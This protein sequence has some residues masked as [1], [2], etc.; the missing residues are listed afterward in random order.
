MCPAA[1]LVVKEAKTKTRCE[2]TH[3]TRYTAFSL[4]LLIAAEQLKLE[5]SEGVKKRG[6]SDCERE[7]VIMRYS[8]KARIT[9]CDDIKN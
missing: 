4:L 7:F 1:S 5:E 3:Q 6:R 9:D 8:L 2:K